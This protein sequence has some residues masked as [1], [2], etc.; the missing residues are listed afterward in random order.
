M[1]FVNQTIYGQTLMQEIS[2][3]AFEKSNWQYVAFLIKCKH[4]I[5]PNKDV[6]I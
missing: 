1:F 3:Y 5:L 2:E 4:D 6:V